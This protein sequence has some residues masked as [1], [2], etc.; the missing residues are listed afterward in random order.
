MRI[1]LQVNKRNIFVQ[2]FCLERLKF[3]YGGGVSL[4]P[5]LLV[6]GRDEINSI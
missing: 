6:V 1:A 4:I 5:L 2:K 3:N